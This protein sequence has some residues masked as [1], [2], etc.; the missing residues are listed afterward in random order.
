LGK[1]A[2]AG[3]KPALKLIHIEDPFPKKVNAAP[4]W[5]LLFYF[6][7]SPPCFWG[8]RKSGLEDIITSR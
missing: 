5:N 7:N 4:H 2:R 1:R 6:C 3:E 8:L